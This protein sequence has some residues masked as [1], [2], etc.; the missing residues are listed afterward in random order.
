MQIRM[1]IISDCGFE[2]ET[3][4]IRS[5]NTQNISDIYAHENIFSLLQMYE[6][7]VPQKKNI[8]N[9]KIAVLIILK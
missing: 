7:K 9:V 5:G 6:N 1:R 2:S 3:E 8:T 4:R